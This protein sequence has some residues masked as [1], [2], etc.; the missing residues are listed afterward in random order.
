[1][2]DQQVV[3]Q[4]AA[5]VNRPPLRKDTDGEESHA[6]VGREGTW[7]NEAVLVTAGRTLNSTQQ[8]LGTKPGGVGMVSGHMGVRVGPVG[9]NVF[10]SMC[11]CVDVG[12]LIP[13]GPGP[14]CQECG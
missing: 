4:K 11:R 10:T 13:E 9:S 5:R 3:G 8:S 14:Q 2:R 12:G 6:E 1:M 7:T